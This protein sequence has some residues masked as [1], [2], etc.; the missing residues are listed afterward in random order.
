[1]QVY[2]GRFAPSPTGSLHLGSLLAAL[3]SYLQAHSQHGEWLVRIEDLDTFRIVPGAADSIFR[4][5]EK[6]H[7]HWH[8]SVV[9][10]SHRLDAYH[11]A[12]EKLK[13]DRWLYPCTCTRKLL[14][15]QHTYPGTCKNSTYS[16]AL[17]HALRV[18][19]TDKHITWM[20]CIQ[21]SC[22]IQLA[23]DCG[24]FIVQRRDSL[25]AYQLAVVVDDAEQG[26]S[27]VV[28]GTDLLDSTPR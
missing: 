15:G 8:G 10:Q 16:P 11:I 26:I 19:T 24:D 20:D 12:L 17:A 14:V 1:M 25:I 13:Q 22:N 2:R 23:E 3:A 7:L 27:E 6:F 9:W 18:K 4:T 21:G 28:R 5:L